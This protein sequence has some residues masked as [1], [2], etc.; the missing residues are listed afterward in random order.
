MTIA[1]CGNCKNDI[2]DAEDYHALYGESR[3]DG[4]S[5]FEDH[6]IICS[7]CV[8]I[9]KK[10]GTYKFLLNISKG[11]TTENRFII[12]YIENL[13]DIAV[14]IGSITNTTNI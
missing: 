9:A 11:I 13:E 2:N 8:D 6:F 4:E 12:T 5:L 7:Q 3:I 14:R 10:D 1:I